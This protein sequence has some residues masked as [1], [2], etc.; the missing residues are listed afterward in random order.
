M[1]VVAVVAHV[2]VLVLEHAVDDADVV[3]VQP[4]LPQRAQLG[5]VLQ[6]RGRLQASASERV[7]LR[8]RL[9]RPISVVLNPGVFAAARARAPA[10]DTPQRARER[11]QDARRLGAGVLLPHLLAGVLDHGLELQ[12][13]Q[14]AA[15]VP[16]GR[17]L[18]VALRGARRRR[19]PRVHRRVR[20][21]P[22]AVQ[23]ALGPA[24]PRGR[25]Q[26]DGGHGR[27]RLLQLGLGFGGGREPRGGLPPQLQEQSLLVGDLPAQ[28]AQVLVFGAKLGAHGGHLPMHGL[29]RPQLAQALVLPE[30]LPLQG[31]DEDH[32]AGCILADALQLALLL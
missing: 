23:R 19:H 17:R 18:Q 3:L 28:V 6:D 5:L 21:R 16:G 32:V 9:Q 4:P 15:E 22:G 25:V 10:D 27:H 30:G 12:A 13:A 29:A 20:G 14:A 11:V 2:R 24:A 8:L 26:A 31:L 7:L 1:V